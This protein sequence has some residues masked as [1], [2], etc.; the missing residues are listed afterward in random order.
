MPH[1]VSIYLDDA[2]HRS[3]KAAASA[4][5][6]SLSTFMA[7]AALRALKRTDRRRAGTDLASLRSRLMGRVAMEEILAW[8][9]EGRE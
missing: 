3:L 9:G 1:K 7:E 5:G 2:S 8:R 4:A 6:V